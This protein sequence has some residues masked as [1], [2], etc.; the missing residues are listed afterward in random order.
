MKKTVF[1]PKHLAL[2]AKMVPFAGFEMPVEYT[3]VR[4]E[5]RNVRENAGVFDVSH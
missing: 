3:G 1:H 4:H 5:H 2:G